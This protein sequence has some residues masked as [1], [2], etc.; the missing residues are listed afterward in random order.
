M[1]NKITFYIEVD[2]KQIAIAD[3]TTKELIKTFKAAEESQRILNS[4]T[5]KSVKYTYEATIAEE[6]RLKNLIAQGTVYGQVTDHLRDEL[7]AVQ[8]V[9]QAYEYLDV[10]NKKHADSTNKAG[11]ATFQFGRILQDSG[12]FAVDF[13]MGML[14]IGNN[15]PGFLEAMKSASTE[16]GGF[17]AGLKAMIGSLSGAT[18]LIFLLSSL[19]AI[20]QLVMGAFSDAEKESSKFKSSIDGIYSIEGAKQLEGSLDE[21]RKIIMSAVTATAELKQKRKELYD[22]EIA[23][24]DGFNFAAN[25]TLKNYDNEIV[26]NQTIISEL[27]AQVAVMEAKLKVSNKLKE[28]GA[29]EKTEDN[30]TKKEDDQNDDFKANKKIGDDAQ[31]IGRDMMFEYRKNQAKKE[32]QEQKEKIKRERDYNKSIVDLAKS[33]EDKLADISR[34]TQERDAKDFRKKADLYSEQ[35]KLAQQVGRA[36]GIGMAEAIQSGEPLLK[37]ALKN[38]L[39]LVLDY[40]EQKFVLAELEA[41]IEAAVTLNP[42]KLI[43]ITAL[44]ASLEAAKSAVASFRE[45][46]YTGEGRRSEPAGNVERGEYVF[47]Q[48]ATQNIGVKNLDNM[49][50]IAK[51]GN[52]GVKDQYR[53]VA[54]RRSSNSLEKRL[55]VLIEETKKPRNVRFKNRSLYESVQDEQNKLAKKVK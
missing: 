43:A 34:E 51:S 52:I 38:S 40:I 46:G 1:S 39:I 47:D 32:E 50:K 26:K 29:K 4:E 20:L 49:V 33:T 45:G 3:A 7:A 41:A 44:V 27:Q 10:T 22:A 36:L 17:G 12:M 6:K 23:G 25:E 35:I 30:S 54:E 8:N 13:R 28:L 16:A 24:K 37:A 53:S 42:T 11:Y 21:T 18:G 19:P 48:Q 5:V 9:R 14:S 15:I 55:D 2:G 31:K